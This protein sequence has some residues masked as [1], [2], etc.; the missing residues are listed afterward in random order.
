[1]EVCVLP[2]E[3]LLHVLETEGLHIEDSSSKLVRLEATVD[4]GIIRGRDLVFEVHLP[5]PRRFSRTLPLEP[6][7]S[8]A[9][10]LRVLGVRRN[11]LPVKAERLFVGIGWS[12][13]VSFGGP[14]SGSGCCRIELKKS[15]ST[16]S[17]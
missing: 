13:I 17:T 3:Y 7:V 14:F 2:R 9:A 6:M 1:M 5:V 16:I 10:L 15:F 11:K 8:D 12:G 4:V